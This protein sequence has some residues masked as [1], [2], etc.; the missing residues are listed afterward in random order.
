MTRRKITLLITLSILISQFGCGP[1]T[2]GI[3]RKSPAE[4][5]VVND[6]DLCYSQ[7]F[8]RSP[9]LMNE[10]SRRNLD[11][12]IRT[13]Q[14]ANA[15]SNRNQDNVSH[16]LSTSTAIDSISI[17]NILDTS[18]IGGCGCTFGFSNSDNNSLSPKFFFASGPDGVAWMNINGTDIQLQ[19]KGIWVNPQEL[20][21]RNSQLPSY[22]GNGYTITT[23][24]RKTESCPPES[25]EC[26]V[27]S[28]NIT[29]NVEKDGLRQSANGKGD[30]GC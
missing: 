23:S 3:A 20:D 28:Y 14:Q 16:P 8:W 4:L 21:M 18:K 27:E 30:C 19:P 29:I 1:N 15:D 10:I 5:R 26:E 22:T 13:S 11:C 25:T 12:N 6:V 7:R 17:G 2:Y 9:N 24:F